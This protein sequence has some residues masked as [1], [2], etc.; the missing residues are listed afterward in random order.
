LIGRMSLGR[1][2]TRPGSW[3]AVCARRS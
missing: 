3:L 1:A 2:L